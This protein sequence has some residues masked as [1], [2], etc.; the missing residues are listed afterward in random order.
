MSDVALQQP[1]VQGKGAGL[2]LMQ[3]AASGFVGEL[4]RRRICDFDGHNSCDSKTCLYSCA[5]E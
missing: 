5:H 3:S 1:R 4:G 2:F